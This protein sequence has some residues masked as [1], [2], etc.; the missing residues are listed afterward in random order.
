MKKRH[1][2]YPGSF[3]PVT[4]GHLD[5]LDRASA[6]FDRITVLVAGLGKAGLLPLDDRVR[7][8][9]ES[10]AH[11]PNVQV[12]GF[13]GLLVEEVRR[14][15]PAALIRGIRTAGDYEH[16]WSLAGVNALL[17]PEIET[18]YFLARPELAA[19]SSTLV[20]DVYRHGGSLDRLVPAPVARELARRPFKAED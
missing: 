2:L 4:L 11:L 15:D 10:V 18:V 7:L 12:Q 9:A 19:I 17:A 5:I 1:V 13:Q 16:E 20:R 3:D 14:H 8:F 6:L